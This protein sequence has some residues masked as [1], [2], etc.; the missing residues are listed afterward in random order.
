M[1]TQALRGSI[2]FGA[3]VLIRERFLIVDD[4]GD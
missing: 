2:P 4:K 1:G 3:W